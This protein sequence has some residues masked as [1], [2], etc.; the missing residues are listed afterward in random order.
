LEKLNQRKPPTN[1]KTKLPQYYHDKLDIKIF[2][3]KVIRQ[4]SLPPHRPG[5]NNAIELKKNEFRR[6]KNVPWGPLYNI[7][8]EKLL[9]L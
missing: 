9:M 6:E 8:K 4:E 7:T 1:P 2:N 5:I 3:P